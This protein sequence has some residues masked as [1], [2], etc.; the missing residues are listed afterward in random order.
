[1]MFP[2]RADPPPESSC[3]ECASGHCAGRA[4]VVCG[5]LRARMRHTACPQALANDNWHGYPLDFLYQEKV[6][7]IEAA[8]AY[9]VWTSVVCFYIEEERGHLMDEE[10]RRSDFHVSMRGKVSPFSMPWEEIYGNL[11]CLWSAAV[12]HGA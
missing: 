1:M 11:H 7:W 2:V 4:G 9:P 12:G 5:T 8:A 3:A 10:L 6:R